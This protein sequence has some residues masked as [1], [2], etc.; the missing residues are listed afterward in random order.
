MIPN[1]TACPL[2]TELAFLAYD[3]FHLRETN[4]RQKIAQLVFPLRK[5]IVFRKVVI[6]D[7]G[8]VKNLEYTIKVKNLEYTIK[9]DFMHLE[10][11]KNKQSQFVAIFDGHNSRQF[12]ACM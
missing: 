11:K 7:K 3:I 9:C 5:D 4:V 8:Q 6:P 2:Y 12:S 10:K 1:Q